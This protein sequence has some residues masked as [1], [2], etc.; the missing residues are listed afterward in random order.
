[1]NLGISGRKVL[2]IGGSKGLGGQISECFNAEG[3][4]VTVIARRVEYLE[5][6]EKRI[7]GN[8][9]NN[10]FISA[11]LLHPGE[12]EKVIS[13]LIKKFGGFD[14]VVH[15]LGGAL[16]VKDIFSS[17]DEWVDVW[18]F[19]IGISIEINNILIPIMIR[20]G[21]GRV[22]HMSSI[23]STIGEPSSQEFGGAI[24]YASSKAYI[25][26]YVQ[27]LG[28]E[29]ASKNVLVNAVLPGAIKSEGKYWDKMVSKDPKL[30]EKFI[31]R[32]SSIGRLAKPE[33][34]ASFVVFLASER[35]TYSAGSLVPV[36]GGR[37]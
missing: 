27:G 3:C 11:D 32:H 4:D 2:V 9:N 29:L 28:R 22:I 1:M 37:V 18:K 24:P 14:I 31:S 12:P 6:L 8:K 34:I 13:S 36:D 30:V 26:S 5:S 16:G 19:N 20:N 33:E 10:T 23:S 15:N 35:A 7:G 21:W 25:N 17:V